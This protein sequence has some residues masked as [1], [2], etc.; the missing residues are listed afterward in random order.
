MTDAQAKT[1][2]LIRQNGGQMLSGKIPTYR[3]RS[4][5]ILVREGFVK[6]VNCGVCDPC[7]L[8]RGYTC[9]KEQVALTSK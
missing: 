8:N 3:Y 1:L 6:I 9:M 7:K 4:I 5:P 2:Q